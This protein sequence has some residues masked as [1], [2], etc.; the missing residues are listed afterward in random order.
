MG[1]DFDEFIARKIKPVE[2]DMLKENLGLS[3]HDL[4]DIIEKANVIIS[5]SY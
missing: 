2:G 1:S 3:E 5:F 4:A